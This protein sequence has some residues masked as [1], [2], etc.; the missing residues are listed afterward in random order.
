MT[1]PAIG[2]CE[3][4]PRPLVLAPGNGG[5]AARPVRPIAHTIATSSACGP[6]ATPGGWSNL[7]E[8]WA[9]ALGRLDSSDFILCAYFGEIGPEIT[10]DTETNAL[11][12]INAP[13][14]D[15][16]GPMELIIP[17][18]AW[19]PDDD[20]VT[21][22]FDTYTQKGSIGYILEKNELPVGGFNF[23]ITVK[24]SDGEFEDDQLY[25]LST[26]RELPS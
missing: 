6:A 14:C 19:D 17:I 2:A 7:R 5:H 11:G 13:T 16:G 23:T 12:F 9:P 1:R 15:T 10:L 8:S 26:V 18:E 24:A 3:C 25:Q 20:P 22:T 4:G 21:I